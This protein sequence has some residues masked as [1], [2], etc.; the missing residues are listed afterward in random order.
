MNIIIVLETQFGQLRVQIIKVQIT[1]DLLYI[2]I[3][4]PV[5]SFAHS[6]VML[7]LSKCF[8]DSLQIITTVS[9]LFPILLYD[10]YF[11]RYIY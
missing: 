3:C 8:H 9:H 10:C 1:E 11:V 6:V 2:T 7:K 4:H 5:S